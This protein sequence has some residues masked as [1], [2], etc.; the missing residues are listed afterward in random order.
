MY[1]WKRFWCPNTGNIK[2]DYGGFLEDPELEH[3]HITN[4][5]VVPFSAISHIPCLVLLGE[6][7]IGKTTAAEQAYKQVQEQVRES[8]DDCLWFNLGDFD[9]NQD[10]S[11]RIF[12]S[13]IFI[14]WINGIHKLHLFLDSLDEGLLSFQIIVR[15]LKNKIEHLPTERLYFR[16]TCRTSVW[17]ESS[18]LEQKLKEKW[19]KS[20]TKIYELA[21]LRRVDVIEAAQVNNIN[22]D[23]FIQ[24]IL[25]R[26][27]TPFAIK[28]VTLKF[29]IG[30]YKNGQF[31]DSKKELYKQGCLQLCEEVNPERL[32]LREFELNSY[33]R[34]IIAGR[35]AVIMIFAQ[36]TAIW[37]SPEIAD[38][39]HSDIDIRDLCIGKESINMQ[40]FPIK[41]KDIR[42]EI[43][44]ITG[45]FSSRGSNRMGFAHQ[46][47][48]EFLAAWYLIEHNIPLV[49]VMSLIVS[50]E[51]PECKLVPQLHETAAWLASMRTDILE[52]II[53]T[54]PDVLLRS[55][56]PTDGKIREKIVDTL[57]KYY[58]DGKL[59]NRDLGSY[60]KYKKLKHPGLAE[61]LR[62]Y[63]H[64]YSK[65]LE[66]RDEAISIAKICEV[67][68]LQEDL[69]NLALDSSQFIHLRA[70]AA[71][72]IG[73]IGDLDTKLKLKTLAISNLEED[74]NDRLK[75][76]SLEAVWPEHLTA[77]ELFNVITPPKRRNY[78]GAYQRFLKHELV[79]KLEPT[80]LLVALKWVEKQGL[81][82]F[83]NP[84]EKLADEII[85]KAWEHFD[86]PRIA[87][88]FAK[89]ALIQR[90]K[91]QRIITSSGKKKIFE[92]QIAEND[93]KRR[94]LIEQIVLLLT[95][96]GVNPRQL[97]VTVREES[98]ILNQDILWMIKKIESTKEE[99]LQRIWAQLVEWGFNRQDA[100]QIDA[101]VTTTQTNDIL[102]N[103]F[104]SYFEAV[105]LNSAEADQMK[106]N[107]QMLEN[108]REDWKND[109]EETPLL[110]QPPKERVLIFLDSL[111]SGTLWAWS[112]LNMEM[113][114]K[115]N[116]RYYDDEL[117]YDLTKLPGWEEADIDT[118]RRI[119]Q[120]AKKY[121]L[122]QDQVANEW[123][124]TDTFDRLAL[125]GCRALF[126]LF[127][128]SPG[129]LDNIAD[130]I[131]QRWAS[132]IV[133]YPNT[134][135]EDYYLELVKQAY[136]K[137]PNETIDTLNLIIDKENEEYSNIFIIDKFDKCWC[138]H[139]NYEILEKI[140]D[141]AL[142]PKVTQRLLEEA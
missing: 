33:Q 24:E 37:T 73:L 55:D 104:T 114:L 48:A 1:N 66:A 91:Y 28:P 31:P 100:M 86:I 16:I 27:A 7:G 80:D 71:M 128:E 74:E 67:Y 25:N 41:E 12:Q 105:E 103:Q 51:D 117:E 23:E 115:S 18:T 108:W 46:T 26:E 81:R 127:K 125:A 20:N 58:N 92:L 61:Q 137:A 136:I 142:K 36:R 42:D 97:L 68:D 118:Q 130:E 8:E 17:L 9:S 94:K 13:E 113:T 3:G 134:D 64:D 85:L 4:P 14:Q 45:L 21:P 131:W 39:P 70:N 69:V 139:F 75:A 44:S 99:H 87:E 54:D 32:Q 47:Y 107:Y 30:T 110:E 60:F 10:L 123:I 106:T 6:P 126:L 59:L 95:D 43:L 34:L 22:S 120:G 82:C 122:E 140:K 121:I 83:E 88:S 119:I 77:E 49:Q 129:F 90:K 72:A 84:F 78:S 19:N 109:Q 133:G 79:P 111:E 53:N 35:L 29:L 57:L 63:I 15:T 89:I 138:E 76:Y 135:K 50:Q 65:S 96:T 124:G 40:S 102:R 56:I 62:P 101:I 5:D 38:I 132:I 112:Q 11:N 141:K 98:I 116:S 52:E 93:E 2:L